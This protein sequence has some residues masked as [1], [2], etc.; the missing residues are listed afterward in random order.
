MTTEEQRE[1]ERKRWHRR[2]ADPEF[3]KR[4]SERSKKRMAEYLADDM[5]RE[6]YNAT[7]R[8]WYRK[9]REKILEY[10]RNWEKRRRAQREML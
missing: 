8:E 3:R 10:K 4:E 2:Y 6:R 7:R 9:N 1:R 5:N